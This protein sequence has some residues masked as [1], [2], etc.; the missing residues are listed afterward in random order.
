M[1]PA[2]AYSHRLGWRERLPSLLLALAA[3]L[4]IV[5]A[6]LR[7]GLLPS[8]PAEPPSDLNSFNVAPDDRAAGTPDTPAAAAARRRATGAAPPTPRPPVPPPPVPKPVVPP[9]PFAPGVLVLDPGQFAAADIG[10]LPSSGRGDAT[11]DGAT[12][13]DGASVYGPGEGPGGERLFNAE[14][15]R[16]PSDAELAGYLPPNGA[17]PGSWATI[18]CRTAERYEVENCRSLGESPAGSGLARAMRQAAWQFRVRPPRI[19]GRPVIGA[20][21]RIRIS[22]DKRG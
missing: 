13:G 15:F 14:W 21:V 19:G 10:R 11:G 16:E 4:L 12:G 9:P 18:A 20:W 17:P 5:L 7:L 2:S 6:L 1:H 3:A 22:F 8:Q